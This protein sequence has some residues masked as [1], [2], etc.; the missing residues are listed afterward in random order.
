MQRKQYNWGALLDFRL[1][2]SGIDLDCSVSRVGGLGSGWV[3][4]GH[5]AIKTCA[6]HSQN[7]VPSENPYYP[8][9][10]ML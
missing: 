9:C 3:V 8:C 4:A 1:L 2:N 7:I 6:L 10:Y 5:P